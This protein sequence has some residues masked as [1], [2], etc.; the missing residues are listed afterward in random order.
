MPDVEVMPNTRETVGR[1]RKQGNLGNKYKPAARDERRHHQSAL[2]YCARLVSTK[3]RT[4]SS[5]AARPRET[6]LLAGA[7]AGGAFESIGPAAA[8]CKREFT[9][10]LT[11]SRA[12]FIPRR[13][14]DT[15]ESA[16]AYRHSRCRHDVSAL[17]IS[18]RKK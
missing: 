4:T 15:N 6:T 7:D 18:A 16:L 17:L 5:N 14:R 13:L 8:P 2:R 1:L 10:A 3:R 9:I 11:G 12:Q